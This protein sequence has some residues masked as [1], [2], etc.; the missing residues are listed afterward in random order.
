[1]AVTNNL[2][3]PVVDTYMPAFLIADNS[4]DI[5]SVT[6]N[7]TVTSY[8]DQEAYDAALDQY[9]YNSDVD[10]VQELWDEYEIKLAAI[11]A[12][13]PDEDDP[14]R[15]EAQRVLRQQ[16]D[17]LLLELISGSS[18]KDRTE[19]IFF[20]DRPDSVQIAKTATF[21]TTNTTK[22]N[23]IC[24][25][26]FSLSMF[27]SI[28]EIANAQVTVRS[29]LTNRTVLHKTKYPC[30]V[31]LKAIQTDTTR[32]TDDKYYIEIRP[33]D[34][35]GLNFIVD[36]YYKVQIRFTSTD[37]EDSGIDL[38]DPDAVQ[39]IDSWLSRNLQYFSEWSTVCL[40]RGISVPTIK[41][42]DF[43]EG[44]DTDIYDTIVNTQ[45]IGVLSF[46]DA[47]ETET[48]RS[49]RLK[50]YDEN[51]NLL[52]DS[53]D[54]YSNDFT[55]INNFNYTFKY[56]FKAN[57]TYHFT[58]TYV[59]QNLYTETH[60]YEF[61]V[62][63]AET[64]D[65]NLQV[66][67]YKDEENGRIGMRVNRSRAKGRYTGQ[68]IIRRASSKDNFTIWEDMYITSYDHVAYIDFTW[69][70]YTIE[71]G[72]FYLYGIQGVDTNG[73][74]TPMTMFK[75]PVMCIF[76]HIFL[77]GNDKQLKIEFNPSLTSFKHTL[78]EARVDTIGSKYPFIKRNG[79]VDYVQFPLGGLISTAMDADGLFT[80]KEKVYADA[81]DYYEEY[82][83][84]NEVKLYQDIVWE[85]FFRDKVSSFLYAD[86][87]RL[88]RSPTEGNFLVRIM[89]VNFQ[90]N[91]T[92][93]RRLW[94]FTSTAYEVDDCN[95]EN[96]K[97]YNIIT[98]DDNT[99]AISG[100]EDEPSTLTPIRR[101]V[102]INNETEFPAVGK[103]Q[104]MYVYNNDFYLWD[105]DNEDYKLISVPLWNQD[106][107]DFTGLTGMSKQLYTD[108]IDLYLWNETNEEYDKISVPI[109]EG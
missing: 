74:R 45:V 39:A 105:E 52:I 87:V 57:N 96:Y 66:T 16:Y 86:E 15:I 51:E 31:M 30:E 23:Y 73:A 5:V 91:Q 75:K 12:Q 108:N 34:L 107:P 40:I 98:I 94:S 48:L 47:N 95:L 64:P 49:Y 71:S 54:I 92:L 100:G 25:V 76:E 89:D 93:G 70:D 21:D 26:Y 106:E 68:L 65:L 42:Q 3:P 84:E 8:V 24:R 2:Y 4:G 78:S 33:E 1:M 82:N 90:P 55:D 104:V 58:L 44:S 6:K 28:S 27:N 81:Y 43:D 101:I 11:R 35:E 72:V 77:T 85:K 80:T 88:F 38:T 50:A 46:A 13:Y 97:K 18:N 7:Y 9:I 61:N 102:F 53:G 109:M 79:Y 17:A 20:E 41:L 99:T 37:A 22:P 67:A 59:T 83:E 103:S 29:Q 32:T 62:L 14:R 19:E 56:W 60:T 63:Q 10:G 36:Q 69:Y